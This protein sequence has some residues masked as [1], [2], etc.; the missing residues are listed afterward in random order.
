MP[1]HGSLIH[2]L[3]ERNHVTLIIEEVAPLKARDGE[4]DGDRPDRG[5][6]LE[7]GVEPGREVRP[8]SDHQ[9]PECGD[10]RRNRTLDSIPRVAF[11]DR[12]QQELERL[13]FR[14]PLG[15]ATKVSFQRVLFGLLGRPTSEESHS[16]TSRVEIEQVRE[17]NGIAVD[18]SHMT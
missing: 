12:G 2:R 6:A 4:R 16:A 5:D 17:S 9:D 1:R 13:D 10:S 18:A 11:L 14:L 8:Q 3:N 15:G 7:K